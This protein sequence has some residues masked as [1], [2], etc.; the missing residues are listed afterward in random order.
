MIT[1]IIMIEGGKYNIY[2]YMRFSKVY[3]CNNDKILIYIKLDKV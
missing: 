2:I 3:L 1:D